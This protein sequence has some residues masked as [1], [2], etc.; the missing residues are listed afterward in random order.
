MYLL[1]APSCIAVLIIG[2]VQLREQLSK[3]AD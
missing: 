2:F 1:F 3:A